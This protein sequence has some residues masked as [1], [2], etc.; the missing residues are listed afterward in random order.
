MM[1]TYS[2]VRRKAL[3]TAAAVL[4]PVVIEEEAVEESPEKVSPEE[5]TSQ[6]TSQIDGDSRG[7]ASLGTATE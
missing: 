1:K 5:V 4:K 2:H 6:V 7:C 3:D